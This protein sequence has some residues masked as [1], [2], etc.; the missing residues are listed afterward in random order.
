MLHCLRHNRV[1]L[2]TAC[3]TERLEEILTKPVCAQHAA[4]WFIRTG[5][6]G[7]FRVAK[8]IGEEDVGGYRAFEDA[9]DW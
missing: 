8:E 4:R 7:Q 9:E 6:L 5:I 1:G 3:G 2:L